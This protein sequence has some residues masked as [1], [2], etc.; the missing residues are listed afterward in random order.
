M[1]IKEVKLKLYPHL[2]SVALSTRSNKK[3]SYEQRDLAV[4]SGAEGA[5]ITHIKN[6]KLVIPDKS[7]LPDFLMLEKKF[8]MKEGNIMILTF[9]ES[10]RK[11]VNAAVIVASTRNKELETLISESFLNK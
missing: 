10:L 5:I 9:S 1:N 3:L 4:K 8:P 7:V 2:K 6:K 11:S